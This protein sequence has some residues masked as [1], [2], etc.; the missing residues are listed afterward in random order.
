MIEIDSIDNLFVRGSGD[1]PDAAAYCV[2]SSKW[3]NCQALAWTYMQH[4]CVS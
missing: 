4:G 1:A 2:A 3:R